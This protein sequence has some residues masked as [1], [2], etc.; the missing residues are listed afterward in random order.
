MAEEKKQPAEAKEQKQ[1]AESSTKKTEQN[2]V[3]QLHRSLN[4]QVSEANNRTEAAERRASEYE[5]QLEYMRQ[6][7]QLGDDE[8]GRLKRLSELEA[9]AE[10][11]QQLADRAIREAT[12]H[13]IALQYDVPPDSEE[14]EELRNAATPEA[15]A[16]V[17]ERISLRRELAELKAKLVSQGEGETESDTSQPTDQ[18]SSF[19]LGEGNLSAPNLEKMSKNEF[20]KH[21]ENQK[22][23]ANRV[24]TR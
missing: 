2:N 12:M 18:R 14:I 9:D 4:R 15:M 8:E 20:D 21:W 7:G 17:G 22:R 16:A 3:A 13:T 10:N 23:Q 6:A 19:D 1:K 24:I 11:K 5:K